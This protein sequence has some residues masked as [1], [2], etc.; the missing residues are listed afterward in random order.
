MQLSLCHLGYLPDSPKLLT[1]VPGKGE[2]LPE[3]IPFYL[4]QNCLRMERD[5]TEEPGFSA[6]FPSPYD[7]LRG[8]L[9]LRDA[10]RAYYSGELVRRDTPWGRL[11]QADFSAFAE[12]GSYQIETDFQISPPFAIRDRMY[13]RL[14]AG[15]L[16]FLLSQRCG[17]EVFG[18]HAACHL[19]DGVLDRDGS[20]WPATGGWHDA[21]DF[22]KWLA[23][24][25]SHLDAV[26]TVLECCGSNLVNGGIPIQSLLDE[27]SWG[28]RFFHAMLSSEGQ[29]FEDVAGGR[30]PAGSSF[31]YQQ[32]WWFENHP[33]CFADASDNRWT[34]NLPGSGDERMVRTTHNP[35][36]Q[37]NFVSTQARVGHLLPGEEAARCVALAR[38]ATAFAEQH[39]HDGR[40]LFLAAEL[41][42][43]LQLLAAGEPVP[44]APIAHLAKELLSRQAVVSNI[45]SGG[46]S[47]YFL[48]A[49]KSDAYRS[50]AFSAE[51][52]LALLRLYELRDLF[53]DIGLA[54]RA[55]DAVTAHIEQYLLADAGS[56]PFSLT[57]YGVY[58]D[59]PDRGRQS[60]RDAGTGRG[61]R[62]FMHPFNTQGIVHGTSSVLLSHAHLLA[63]A[64]SQLQT[65]SWR[66]PA[67]RLLQWCLGSNPLNRSLFSGIGY[68][69]PVGYSFRIPQIPEAPVTGF[70]GRPDDTPYLETTTAIEWNTLEY[71]SIP[72]IQAAQAACWLQF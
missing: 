71:W 36:V 13:D 64:S 2:P 45:Q 62:T 16:T 54:H 56:N 47:G 63:R 61:V 57:P 7:L 44:Q 12:R 27:I 66:A 46:L 52:A 11:W 37:W 4:R 14:I 58:L 1:L 26:A 24:T 29:V 65:P 30:A 5:R 43:R 32:H 59:P 10:A 33:G 25:Q 28:N 50:I 15:Y 70:I 42:G 68:G 8:P 40:T 60:F 49:D 19:D 55:K 35:L 51:P 67:E 48:E 6:R 22:R 31:S 17:C 20:P 18:V 21:G 34:D 23:F 9:T 3:R 69:Q 39:P 41:R 72:Y 38:R 53:E